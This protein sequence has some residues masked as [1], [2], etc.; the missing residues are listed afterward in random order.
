MITDSFE[1]KLIEVNN[2][3]GLAYVK[4]KHFF[5]ELLDDVLELTMDKEFINQK[6]SKS[7]NKSKHKINKFL[8]L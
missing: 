5:I 6:K 2:K 3:I 7:D 4:D 1:V 8:K